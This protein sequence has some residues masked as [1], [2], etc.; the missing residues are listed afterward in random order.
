MIRN[1]TRRWWWHNHDSPCSRV[2]QKIFNSWTALENLRTR[3]KSQARSDERGRSIGPAISR[4]SITFRPRLARFQSGFYKVHETK[5]DHTLFSCDLTSSLWRR[6]RGESG[7]SIWCSVNNIP[8]KELT[9]W[10]FPFQHRDQHEL[11]EGT[12]DVRCFLLQGYF[13]R[14][15]PWNRSTRR[16]EHGWFKTCWE[17]EE[18][19]CGTR[20]ERKNTRCDWI[21]KYRICS[22]ECDV[23]R[24]NCV[25]YDPYRGCGFVFTPSNESCS[26][27]PDA[28]E[29]LWLRLASR[30][31]R[32]FRALVWPHLLMLQENNLPTPEHRYNTHTHHLLGESELKLLR[33]NTHIMNYSRGELVDSSAMKKLYSNGELTGKYFTDFVEGSQRRGEC[34][35][36]ASSWSLHKKSWGEFSIHGSWPDP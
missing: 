26:R 2:R 13:G 12:H 3:E 36:H 32:G 1:T 8:V 14:I 23:C 16:V 9:I 15:N 4:P 20:V 6:V 18:V 28:S 31:V 24:M 35:H 19:V 22:H 11:G 5:E 29:A 27:Y 17:G 7:G 30:A 33:P 25:G 34:H 10:V 21:G